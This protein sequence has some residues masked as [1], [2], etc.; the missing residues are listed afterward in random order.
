MPDKQ[1]GF[2][3]VGRMGIHMAGRLIDAGYAVTVF[4][5]NEIAMQRLEQRGAKRA[6]SA[7]E[8]ASQCET[9]LVS[10]PTPDV[11][12]NV[13]LGA[14][15]VIEGRKVKT[16]VDLSATGPRGAR[17]VAGG[18]ARKGHRARQPA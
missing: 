2:I 6:A 15:G 9:V 7:A 8:V 13:A 11:V 1:L 14:A 18:P 4:D 17:D 3:G 12:P 10:L 16:F 5:T